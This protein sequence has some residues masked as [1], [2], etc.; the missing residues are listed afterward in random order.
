MSRA[1]C[2][3]AGFSTEAQSAVRVKKAARATFF[4][5]AFE[6]N[7]AS[8][9]R[10]GAA[11]PAVGL[12][13]GDSTATAPAT[14][15]WFQ[16]CVFGNYTTTDAR[17][18]ELSP[19]KVSIEDARSEVYTNIPDNPLLWDRTN[20]A[21]ARPILVGPGDSKDGVFGPLQLLTED[22]EW[23]RANSEVQVPVC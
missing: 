14:A 5:T 2:L 21:V 8:S 13:S 16:D 4:R 3:F 11:G 23:F 12:E 19:H 18:V 1:D 7:R 10:G 6:D 15:A 9:R 20:G 17:G 22:D